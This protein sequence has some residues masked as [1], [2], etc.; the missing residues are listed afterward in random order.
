[1]SPRPPCAELGRATRRAYAL[2]AAWPWVV[3]SVGASGTLCLVLGVAW[4][5]R[6]MPVVLTVAGGLLV[7]MAG[8]VLS[9]L[10]LHVGTARLYR[11]AAR[12]EGLWRL[13][14]AADGGASPPR[15]R[16]GA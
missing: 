8:V 15:E 2:L 6:E 5:L 9:L 14:R 11:H 12:L 16:V 1:M 4:A 3:G 7:G 10:A 13:A